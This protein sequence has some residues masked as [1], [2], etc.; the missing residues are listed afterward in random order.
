MTFS[1]IHLLYPQR[2]RGKIHKDKRHNAGSRYVAGTQVNYSDSEERKYSGET[3]ELRATKMGQHLAQHPY[4]R[5]RLLNA[6]V[7]V[8]AIAMSTL[9]RL[10][11]WSPFIANE[12]L[13]GAN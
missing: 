10:T 3:M 7:E 13:C 4:N 6:G 8:S 9:F 1:D 12:A 5:V 2:K 11:N